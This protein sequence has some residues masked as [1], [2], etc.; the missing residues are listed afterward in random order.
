MVGASTEWSLYSATISLLVD[1]YCAAR[2][3][4]RTAALNTLALTA[5]TAVGV[6]AGP[7]QVVKRV[8]RVPPRGNNYGAY[9][10][11]PQQQQQQ[12]LQQQ[13][14][15]YQASGSIIGTGSYG[16]IQQAASAGSYQQPGGFNYQQAAPAG[17]YQQYSPAPTSAA[18]PGYSSGYGSAV[19]GAGAYGSFAGGYG[20]TGG[21]YQQQPQ[22]QQ[23]YG[24]GGAPGGYSSQPVSPPMGCHPAFCFYV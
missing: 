6:P 20:S 5:S 22:P 18:G 21:G 8:I 14:P 24:F 19:G 2:A 10:Q 4:R 15:S 23:G 9:Q 13:G 11:Q 16:N 7:P 3:S 17:N 1:R 12:Q